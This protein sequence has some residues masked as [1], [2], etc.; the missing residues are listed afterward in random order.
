MPPTSPLQATRRSAWSR[1]TSLTQPSRGAGCT[2]RPAKAST[3]SRNSHGRPEAAAADDHAVA[4]GLGEHRQ[5]VVGLPD[6][7]VAEHRDRGD[8]GL[9]GGDGVPPRRAAVELLGG[10][11]VE[12]DGRHALLLG[13]PAGVEV[14][15][16][17][18]VD[19]HAEL[20]RDGD[21]PGRR[22][23]GPDDVAQQ[24]AV[25]GERRAAALPGDLRD[26]AAEVHVDVVDADLVDEVAHRLAERARV[27]AVEL[28]RAGRLGA[29]EA[30]HRERARV[31]LDQ[32]PSRDHLR[33]VEPGS[34]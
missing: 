8:V 4:A 10:A 25:H 23:R 17:R 32:R 16:D 1:M 5:R 30:Q 20:D 2:S 7:A 34:R 9:E 11:G 13:D 22:H 6:V 19:A 33:H 14:G 24:R 26:R 3:R 27:G 31:A 21:R 15:E 29:V 28:H 12:R 18:V